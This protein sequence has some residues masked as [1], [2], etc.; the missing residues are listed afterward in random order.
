MDTKSVLA[1]ALTAA[2]RVAL[3]GAGGWLA[4]HGIMQSSGIES[5]A[6]QPPAKAWFLP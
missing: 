1:A 2:A 5:F 6:N 3:V 4:N